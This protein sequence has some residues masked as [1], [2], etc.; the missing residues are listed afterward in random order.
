MPP[1][2]HRAEVRPLAPETYKVQF[3][4]GRETF[5]KLREVQ[6]LLR[7]TIPNGDVAEIFSRALSLLLAELRK[8][9]CA[10][11]QRP[12]REANGAGARGRHVP[13]AVKRTVWARDGGRCAFVGT[14][15]RCTEQGFLEYHHL[16]PFADGGETTVDNLQLRCRAHNGYEAERWG[17]AR[18]EDLVRERGA[19]RGVSQLGP[20]RV[21]PGG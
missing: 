19:P 21:A 17:G 5:D 18:D 13:S 14:M 10:A 6:D 7:H 15:G 4:V 20:D 11:V 8:T 12:R 2:P 3:T 9:K 16:V 1:P